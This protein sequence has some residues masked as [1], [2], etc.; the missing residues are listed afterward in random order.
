MKTLKQITVVIVLITLFSSCQS[1]T[2][3]EQILSKPETRKAIMD[4]I[5]NNS[6]MSR[7]MMES[8]M[9]SKN[10]KMMLL[11]NGKM[12]G[13]IMGNREGMMEMFKENPTIMQDMM[14]DI[15][16]ASKGDSSIMSSMIKTMMGNQQIM[17][18]M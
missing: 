8:M 17:E 1:G 13:M 9:N 16:G 7:E 6:A 2:N 3:V 18:I 14:S 15:I 5:A 4:S 12:M 10:G 11:G